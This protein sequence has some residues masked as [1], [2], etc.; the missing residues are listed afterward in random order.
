M[1]AQ[2]VTDT[3]TAGTIARLPHLFLATL[4]LG[5]VLDH[6]LPLPFPVARI[7]NHLAHRFVPGLLIFLGL[8]FLMAGIRKF[9]QAKTAMPP[10]QPALAPRTTCFEGWTRNPVFLGILLLCLGIGVAVQS[11]WILVLV[12]LFTIVAFR[13]DMNKPS[14]H[15][16]Y[17]K[18]SPSIYDRL[19]GRF[20]RISGG[21]GQSAAE[22]AIAALLRPGLNILDAGCG[23]GRLARRLLR[24]E[25]GL[26]LTLLDQSPRLL[27][28]TRDLPV[29]RVHG[30]LTAMPL[31]DAL[32]D[33]TLAL[34]SI[35]ATDD[36]EAA[37]SEL[38]R[39]T[40][41]G[42][43]ICLLFCARSEEEDALDRMMEWGIRLRGTGRFLD[44]EV[45]VRALENAGARHV[46]RLACRGPAAALLAT[47]SEL[48]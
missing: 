11:P 20:L 19:H 4:P 36:P 2:Q 32:F 44:P 46:R 18:Q 35:E 26:E 33:L 10:N 1:A 14:D 45:M 47:R 7:E 8:A 29:A 9:S 31:A 13:R 21:E 15:I 24:Q 40:R 23:T 6:L 37:I 25:A 43:H 3:G 16:G 27:R 30:D 48:S 38:M 34:W 22:G 39:V 28:A 17:E 42:G 12:L 41:P 5:F